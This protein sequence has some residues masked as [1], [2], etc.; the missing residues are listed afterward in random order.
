MAGSTRYT[1]ILD[2]NVLYPNLMRDI[3]LSMA[4][5]G[6]YQAR[7][8]S[9]INDEWTRN[10]VAKKPEISTK[11]EQLLWLVNH[12]VPDCL[13]ENYEFLINTLVLPDSDD[14]HVLAAAIAAHAGTIV[15]LN[16]KDFPMTILGKHGIEAQHPDDFIMNQIE[17]RP[18]DSLEVIK[19]VRTRM[20]NPAR[21]AITLVDILDKSGLHQTAKYLNSKIDLI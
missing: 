1:A 13:V 10:L 9:R 6:L 19:R 16:L 15:T 2:A 5:V 4:S 21:S 7:W 3:L 14:R 8:T 18:F 20:R 12:S 17:I 11:I